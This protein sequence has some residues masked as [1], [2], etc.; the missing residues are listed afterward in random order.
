M[1]QKI[2]DTVREALAGSRKVKI[3]FKMTATGDINYLLG[4]SEAG[5]IILNPSDEMVMMAVSR[6]GDWDGD[7]NRSLEV[8]LSY[9]FD[10]D[11][12][13]GRMYRAL[14]KIEGVN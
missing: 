3:T 8:T 2:I 13:V 6:S 10:E 1:R 5:I 14:E 9:K 12:F 11:W 4:M 7:A